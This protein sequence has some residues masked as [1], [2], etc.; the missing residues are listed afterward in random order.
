M[1]GYG[2]QSNPLEGSDA[3]TDKEREYEAN[4]RRATLATSAGSAL[5]YYDFALYGLASALIFG[6]LFFPALP[7][8]LALIASFATFGVGFLARPLGALVF[9][10]IGDRLGRK[11][12]LITT[13]LLMG[14]STTLIGLLPTGE[15][16]GMWAP[17]LLVLLRLIQ[18][19]GAGAEQAGSTT[20]M[21][22]YA[23]VRSRGFI[24]ALPFVGIYL[25][26]L[27]SS[28]VVALVSLAPDSVLMSWLW[29]V[30]FLV[31][32]MLIVLSVWIRE[33]LAESPTF[34]TLKSED[35]VSEHPLKELLADSKGMVLKG[36]GLRMAENGGS[37]LFQTLAVSFAVTYGLTKTWG[38]LA[39]AVASV[40][41]LFTVPWAGHL[42][43][44]YGRRIVYRIGAAVVV[45]VSFPGWYLLTKGSIA[46]AMVII[47]IAISFGVCIMLGSQCAFMPELFGSRRRYIGVAVSREVSAVLAGGIA[48][49][50]G[51]WLL[52]VTHESWIAPAVYVAVLGLITFV[53]TFFVPETKGRDLSAVEDAGQTSKASP[54]NESIAFTNIAVKKTSMAEESRTAILG[55]IENPIPA[56]TTTEHTDI[57]NAAKEQI[58]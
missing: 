7:S 31:S 17:I 55:T 47:T 54:S 35:N 50:L 14:G 41:A 3:P 16:I 20:L 27:L 5:E 44:I 12:V 36:I 56:I 52:Y 29:R 28:G 34:E 39:V 18:G 45:L 51:S 15:Q 38:S 58:A 22:E 30:P 24:S 49:I 19:F 26:T 21:A 48:P 2:T 57:K 4:L 13:I 10:S 11:Q 23:P 9:G 37:Y 33:R 25:G 8:S 32:I 42:S 40:V 1:N 53:T 6:K 43:D 46:A